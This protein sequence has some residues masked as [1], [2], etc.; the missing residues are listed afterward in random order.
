MQGRPGLEGWIAGGV[1][2]FLFLILFVSVCAR[3]FLSIAFDWLEELSRF[4][5]I[6]TI[7]LGAS[8]AVLKG[9]HIRVTIVVDRLPAPW[10][11]RLALVG[12]VIWL[13]FNV[14][15]CWEGIRFLLSFIEHPYEAT[16]L[17]MSMAW[18]FAII[19]IGFGLMSVRLA[20]SL[21]HTGR[22][23]TPDRSGA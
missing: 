12:D 21:R 6:W 15:L 1:L 11:G 18:F 4:A 7:Y 17:R 13:L 2:G 16:T 22:G 3:F 9:K 5:F 14:V 23:G 10:N 20:Q 8:S 19:P